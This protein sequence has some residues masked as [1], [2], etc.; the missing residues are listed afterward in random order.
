[1]FVCVLTVHNDIK[2]YF[3]C[4]SLFFISVFHC[5]FYLGHLTWATTFFHSA[6]SSMCVPSSRVLSI[7]ESRSKLSIYCILL[8]LVSGSLTWLPEHQS[9]SD[10]VLMS[11]AMI[12][13]SQ[14]PCFIVISFGTFSLNLVALWVYL[15]I[16]LLMGTC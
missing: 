3:Y 2:N 12:G 16:F 15:D 1:M 14:F 11:P 5:I 13:K 4:P 9:V 10:L 8:P 7:S 6:L